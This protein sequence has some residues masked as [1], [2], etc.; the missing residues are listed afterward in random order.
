MFLVPINLHVFVF[1]PSAYFLVPI[2]RTEKWIHNKK[3]KI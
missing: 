3:N 2:K 1:S